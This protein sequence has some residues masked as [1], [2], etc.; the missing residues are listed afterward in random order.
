VQDDALL[1][2]AVRQHDDIRVLAKR[3]KF[4]HCFSAKDIMRRWAALL[5]D[6]ETSAEVRSAIAATPCF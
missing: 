3:V 4:S 5:Y 6:E 2:E 1:K